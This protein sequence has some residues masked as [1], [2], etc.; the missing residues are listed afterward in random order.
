M[1]EYIT[2]LGN[3][4]REIISSELSD[5]FIRVLST[6]IEIFALSRRA[7][8]PGRLTKYGRKG[9]LGSDDQV[10]VAVNKLAILI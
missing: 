3:F 1:K 9:L 5:K 7:I 2:R 6:L 8:K 10:K 4:S